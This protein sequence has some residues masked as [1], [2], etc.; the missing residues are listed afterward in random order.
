MTTV[1]VLQGKERD[2]ERR[3]ILGGTFAHFPMICV[4]RDSP[5]E[6]W[7]EVGLLPW[8]YVPSGQ[9][10]TAGPWHVYLANILEVAFAVPKDRKVTWAEALKDTP[11]LTY[12]NLDEFFDDGWRLD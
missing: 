12:Q 2:F 7:P 11:K 9:E 5:G 4:K 3:L 8:R 6:M 1:R 10:L